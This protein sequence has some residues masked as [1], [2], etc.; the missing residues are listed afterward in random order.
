MEQIGGDYVSVNLAC[1]DGVDP[2]E[3]IDAPLRYFDGRDNNWE[4]P[5]AET[6]H[7]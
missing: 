2:R 7:L 5:P 6:R 4:N 1:L 3:L